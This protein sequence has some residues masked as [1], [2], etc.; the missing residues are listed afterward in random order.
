MKCKANM[1]KIKCSKIYLADKTL[2][3]REAA[4]KKNSM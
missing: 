1:A 3:L 2:F 4:Y